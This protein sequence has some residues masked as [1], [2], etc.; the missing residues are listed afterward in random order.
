MET[1][2]N[3]TLPLDHV[4]D[5]SDIIFGLQF[6]EEVLDAEAILSRTGHLGMSVVVKQSYQRLERA[7]DYLLDYFT[8][9]EQA[10]LRINNNVHGSASRLEGLTGTDC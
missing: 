7:R 4:G 2:Q 10:S 3:N 5:I 6:L 9:R 1:E 8:Q